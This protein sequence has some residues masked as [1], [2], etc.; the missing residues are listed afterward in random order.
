MTT[1]TITFRLAL[2][3]ALA[4]ISYLAT[5]GQ[6]F[7]VVRDISDKAN[8]VLAFG[9][10]ALL[11]DFSFPEEPFGS[12]KIFMLLAYGLLIE[13]VQGLLPNRAASLLDL[14]ADGIG[15][16]AYKFSV[17]A[18]KRVPWLKQRWT[19]AL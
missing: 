10:L 7:P 9:A 14:V 2:I 12:S 15:I 8:H 4:A 13:L 18:L 3:A 5:I 11:V 6:D 16:A 17:P 19:E 1:Q